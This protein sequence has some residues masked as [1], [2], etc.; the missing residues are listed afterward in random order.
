M[1]G[2]DDGTFR[3]LEN[4]PTQAQ[5]LLAM[6]ATVNSDRALAVPR[7][8]K[9][10]SRHVMDMVVRMASDA[11]M[12]NAAIAIAFVYR[13][14]LVINN[15]R[16]V[17]GHDLFVAYATLFFKA[18]PVATLIALATFA[19]NGFYTHGRAYRSRYKLLSIPRGVLF[20]AWVLTL[21][22]LEGAR[23]WSTVWSMVMRPEV[24]LR[25]NP[26]DRQVER[27]LVIGGAGYIGSAL[28]RRLLDQ[29]YRVRLLDLFVYGE[30]PIRDLLGHP[31]LEVHHA[32]FRQV[33]R[34]AE[35]MRDMDAVIHLGAIVGDPACAL[36]E[37]LTI[38]VNLMATRMIAEIAKGYGVNRFIFA[39]T[40]S[41][42]G[43]SDET[44]DERSAL[45][46]LS[47]YARSKIASER[48]LM[49]MADDK[50][51]PVILRFGTIF[52][53]SGRT[54]FDLVVN[55]LTAK[56]IVD[57][58][59]T[60]MGGDQWR[61]F[62]H[63]QDAALAAFK[64]LEAPLQLV[65]RQIFNVGSDAQNYTLQDVGELIQRVVPNSRV[66]ELGSNSDHRNYRVSFTKIRKMLSFEPQWTLERGI[67]QVKE[68][69]ASGKIPDYR[70]ALYNNFKF[71]SEEGTQRLT[72]PNDWISAVLD[73]QGPVDQ[74]AF[75]EMQPAAN[76][77]GEVALV[78]GV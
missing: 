8:S 67:R 13:Y 32:D 6:N 16:A 59:I 51:F 26:K 24:A 3:K 1:M 44:L 75:R 40:C 50:F 5:G 30:E 48:V 66:V 9:R 20:L 53:L 2:Q 58:E 54:R 57:G 27:V 76:D 31:N 41:V 43:A 25:V 78:G 19:C 38:D 22:F 70:L 18:S 52:G 71:L 77:S 39:S 73:A 62:V 49:A 7:I 10:A 23:L 4:R 34:V 61:P 45:N 37:D 29:G 56:A 63:V 47:L 69:F 55:L 28:L 35:A 12:V 60:V 21:A 46:P 36:D 72:R 11:L 64:A 33:D 65:D 74:V 42:Y 17:S 15:A 14:I 68:A